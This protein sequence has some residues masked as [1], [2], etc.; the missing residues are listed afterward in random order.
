MIRELSDR[1]TAVAQISV[2][3]VDRGL[4]LR[5]HRGSLF[6]VDGLVYPGDDRNWRFKH[7]AVHAR[8]PGPRHWRN[9]SATQA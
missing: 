4:S 7:V 1:V 3:S 9:T 6:E 2:H 8:A 5:L